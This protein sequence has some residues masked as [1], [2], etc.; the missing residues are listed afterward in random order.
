MKVGIIA[1]SIREGRNGIKVAEWVDEIAQKRGDADYELIDL[2]K[3]NVPL[4][5]DP[6]HP[7]MAGGKYSTPEVQAWSAAIGSC[8]AFVFV[9]PEYNHSVPGAFK[10]AVD[11]LAVEWMGKPVGFVSYGSSSGVRAVEAWRL[12]L[13]NFGM[14]DQRAAVELGLFTEFDDQGN[15]TPA[16]RRVDEVNAMLDSVVAATKMVEASK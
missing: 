16:E 2:K 1:G 4:L 11:S 5:T 6:R 3:F 13:A 9:T 8:D 15:F 12:S 10:N 7:A 14:L